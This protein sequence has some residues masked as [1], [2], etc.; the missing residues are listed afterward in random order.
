M[1]PEAVPEADLGE[2]TTVILVRHGRT[3]DTDQRRARGGAQA[4]PALNAPG[5]LQAAR[6][7]QVLGR[8]LAGTGPDA[9]GLGPAGEYGD[10]PGWFLARPAAILTSPLLRARQTA[11]ALGPVLDLEPRPDAAWAELS[12]GD[13]DGL[14][15]AEIAAGWPGEFR[16]WRHSPSVAP[17][18]GESMDDVAK[19]VS[20]ARDRLIEDYPGQ[21]VV[22][23]SHTAPIRTVIARALDAGP[24]A[25]WRLRINPTSVSVVRFWADGGCEVAAVNST[26]ALSSFPPPLDP[27]FP[28]S[29]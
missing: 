12:L 22:V 25:L 3:E 19:R 6:L 26:V 14:G 29:I 8:L 15:Y 11:H 4:G 17:P 23:V 2:P 21:A 7:A 24:V 13:W 18:G 9:G 27:H 20:A 16:Q 10:A 1:P 5:R 28:G